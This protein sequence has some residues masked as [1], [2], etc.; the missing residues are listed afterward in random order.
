MLDLET[1][2][3]RK[4]II[5]TIAKKHGFEKVYI[6]VD[7]PQKDYPLKLILESYSNIQGNIKPFIE[8]AKQYYKDLDIGTKVITKNVLEYM[9]QNEDSH[10]HQGYLLDSAIQLTSLTSEPLIAQF[11]KQVQKTKQSLEDDLNNKENISSHD[12]KKRSWVD[13]ATNNKK[14]V[15]IQPEKKS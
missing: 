2:L 3:E 12:N 4:D 5:T 8:E 13:I 1:I 9:I 11:N 15:E 6:A 7:E 14:D 10:I